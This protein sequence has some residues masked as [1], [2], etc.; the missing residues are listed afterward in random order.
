LKFKQR[1]E[2]TEERIEQASTLLH[3][4]TPKKIT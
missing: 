1:M 2:T 4:L 3:L